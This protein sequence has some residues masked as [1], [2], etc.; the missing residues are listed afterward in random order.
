MNCKVAV[1][2]FL[3][4]SV[5]LLGN[6]HY[7]YRHCVGYKLP[8]FWQTRRWKDTQGL[9]VVSLTFCL[10]TFLY[11]WNYDPNGIYTSLFM[12]YCL[13]SRIKKLRLYG[14]KLMLGLGCNVLFSHWLDG[15]ESEWTLGVGDG[16]GGLAC[17]DSWGRKE[18]DTTEWLIWS[19]LIWMCNNIFHLLVYCLL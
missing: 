2:I 12:T 19:D 8:C 16:Q 13:F 15:R 7:N 18:S 6:Q 3:T 4:D 1:I 5:T 11:I 14:I 9:P 17:C 10:F